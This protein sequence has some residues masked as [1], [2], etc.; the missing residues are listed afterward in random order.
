M[1]TSTSVAS[2]ISRSPDIVE[3]ILARE[4]RAEMT[5]TSLTVDRLVP[6]RLAR[7]AAVAR[8]LRRLM[9]IQSYLD[10]AIELARAYL[11]H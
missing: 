5:V 2:S 9:Q 1:L 11:R 4:Q 7:A 3:S 6:M 8:S 10:V